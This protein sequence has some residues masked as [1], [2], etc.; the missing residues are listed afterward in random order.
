MSAPHAGGALGPA[1]EAVE[2]PT[3]SLLVREAAALL[4]AHAVPRP[5]Q[6]AR[7]LVAAVLDR[8][9]FWPAL[10]PDDRP[11]ADD[12]THIRDAVR[13][14]VLG[15][16]FAYAVRKASFRFLTLRVDEHVL[17]PRPETEQLVEH[18]LAS[19]QGSAG[20][21]AV[22]VGTGSGAIAL[23]LAAEGRFARVV[24]TEVSTDAL[25]VAC[26]NRRL[27]E[28]SL[29]APVDLRAGSGLAPL[30]TERVDVVVANPP[31]IAY[32]ELFELPGAVRNWE[33]AQALC[34]DGE[35]LSVTREII[36][37]AARHLNTGGLLA[38]EVDCRRAAVVAAMVRATGGF[39]DVSMRRDY[40]G[41]DRFV[42]ATR[43]ASD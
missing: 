33:P 24:A 37:G 32:R 40:A 11:P 1:R 14:R 31:Y 23:A 19:P 4:A 20:G 30:G 28:A 12:V 15:A 21:V 13:R 26:E 35:G 2:A 16:P 8:P 17:I 29:R 9:R 39:A 22:D 7:D 5:A 18:V 34:C 3:L 25:R 42:L 36:G 41:R 27:C 43:T 10:H 6:E 38:L